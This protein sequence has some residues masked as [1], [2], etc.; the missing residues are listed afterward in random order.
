MA[1]ESED[2]LVPR[3]PAAYPGIAPS[4]QIARV[5]EK[6]GGHR[7]TIFASGSV[8]VCLQGQPPR[9]YHPDGS[10]ARSDS[11]QLVAV[12]R[13]RPVAPE[14]KPLN[15][16]SKATEEIG[17]ALSN[18]ALRHFI[19]DGRRYASVEAWYQG[20]KWPEKKKR[21]EIARLSGALAKRAG[22]GAPAATHFEYEGAVYA[23]GSPEHHELVKR[24]IRASLATS[25]QLSQEFIQTYPRPIEH[26]T[27][28]PE[29][30][31]SALPASKF[32]EIL[33]EIR[34]ELIAESRSSGSR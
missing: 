2:D 10:V 26:D 5:I 4:D 15:V 25:E 21:A 29:R 3:D 20:L 22:H 19:L 11:G 9:T 16:A 33:T 23:V 17:Q 1:P 30:P 28:R 6:P 18:F 8:L 12:T 34:L 32:T 31:G 24:A 27:G 14:Q 7:V 13:K